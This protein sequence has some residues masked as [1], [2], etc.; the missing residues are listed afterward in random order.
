[1]IN[2]E[3]GWTDWFQLYIFWQD[4]FW[5]PL[6]LFSHTGPF[7]SL[8]K[9]GYDHNYG[10]F[11]WVL[12]KTIKPNKK[13]FEMNHKKVLWEVITWIRN[14]DQSTGDKFVSIEFS[15]FKSQ[16]IVANPLVIKI[17]SPKHSNRHY[18][19]RVWSL[20]IHRIR[21]WFYSN[22]SWC[23]FTLFS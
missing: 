4:A 18:S 21:H 9:F 6:H 3:N 23:C 11:T 20:F 12:S 13:N 15:F 17:F 19:I 16:I 8:T 22:G 5:S 14:M 2:R 1:M 10:D 7:R